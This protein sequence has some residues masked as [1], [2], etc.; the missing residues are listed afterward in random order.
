MVGDTLR[1]VLLEYAKR[2]RE[3]LECTRPVDW[4][5][6]SVPISGLEATVSRYEDNALF[7][8]QFN[9]W[10]CRVELIWNGMF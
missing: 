2:L 5:G 9:F 4:R 6:K 7:F 3:R 1:F 10:S 8:S